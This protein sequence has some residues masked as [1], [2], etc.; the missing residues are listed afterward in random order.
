MLGILHFPGVLPLSLHGRTFCFHTISMVV[1]EGWVLFIP[2][3]WTQL[4]GFFEFVLSLTEHFLCS[5]PHPRQ[6]E[7]GCR[8]GFPAGTHFHRVDVGPRVLRIHLPRVSIF[9][10]SGPFC[11][12]G[13][14]QALLLCFS[15]S[16]STGFSSG[17]L[18]SFFGLE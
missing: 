3:L 4:L 1:C 6:A 14:F 2:L 8:P 17:C 15:M 12:K 16:R 18:G 9:P 7:C 10:D 5:C 13:H 11:Y